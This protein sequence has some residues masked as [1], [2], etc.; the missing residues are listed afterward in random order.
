MSVYRDSYFL[1]MC[2]KGY[3]VEC[4]TL[5]LHWTCSI[6]GWC[7]ISLVC[8]QCSNNNRMKVIGWTGINVSTIRYERI[9][10]IVKDIAQIAD[11]CYL[12]GRF[13]QDP[14]PVFLDRPDEYYLKVAYDPRNSILLEKSY[15]P[16]DW[17]STIYKPAI[18]HIKEVIRYLTECEEIN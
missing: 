3:C 4:D 16:H 15:K 6:E 5:I 17:E 10:Y 2:V 7:V 1:K 11:F 9:N 8:S 14:T 13:I 18:I 12:T